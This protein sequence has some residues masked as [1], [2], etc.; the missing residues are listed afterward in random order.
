MSRYR[1][2]VAI[3]GLVLGVAVLRSLRRAHIRIEYSSIWILSAGS[4][5]VVAVWPGLL[6][7]AAA[8]LGIGDETFFLLFMTIVFSFL[9]FRLSL[10]VSRLKDDNTVLVQR[11][12]MLEYELNKSSQPGPPKPG[13]RL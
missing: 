10:A 4:I 8:L 9:M 2:A 11:V 13:E 3:F 5:V 1:A 7:S 12:A 6:T